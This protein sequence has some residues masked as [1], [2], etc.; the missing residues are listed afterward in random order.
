MS[1]R[2]AE[3][4]GINEQGSAHLRGINGLE[5]LLQASCFIHLSSPLFCKSTLL[6]HLGLSLL[7]AQLYLLS[8]NIG[9]A[10]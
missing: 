7:H 2:K 3:A 8:A 5:A 9:I 4:R 1:S 6:P 10:L